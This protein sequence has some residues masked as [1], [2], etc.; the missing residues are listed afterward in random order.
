VEPKEVAERYINFKMK[1]LKL[2]LVKE[3]EEVEIDDVRF[4]AHA[5]LEH[6]SAVRM[7]LE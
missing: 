2:L 6:R 3:R 7:L 4:I 1:F 5:L